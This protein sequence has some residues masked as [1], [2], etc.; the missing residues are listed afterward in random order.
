MAPLEARLQ[1][2]ELTC[3]GL[4]GLLKTRH[5]YSDDELMAA[6]AEVDARDGQVDGK[7]AHAAKMCPSCGRKLLIRSSAKCAWCGQPLSP[8]AS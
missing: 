2:L 7:I 5:G 1:A 6:I 4:W 8:K 3:A